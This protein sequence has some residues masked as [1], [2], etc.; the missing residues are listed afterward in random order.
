MVIYPL[1]DNTLEYYITLKCYG[2]I[3]PSSHGM[4][5]LLNSDLE[6]VKKYN[7]VYSFFQLNIML[8]FS[9]KRLIIIQSER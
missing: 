4:E 9:K 5:V 8:T 1:N 2:R 6:I 3:Q 7:H